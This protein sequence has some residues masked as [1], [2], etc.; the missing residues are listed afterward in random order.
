MPG[1]FIGFLFYEKIVYFYLITLKL[2]PY[3]NKDQFCLRAHN[4]YVS[5]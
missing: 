1:F 4:F 3:E 5:T 2:Q